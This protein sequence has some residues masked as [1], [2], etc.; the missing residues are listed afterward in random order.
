MTQPF[1][2]EL[3]GWRDLVQQVAVERGLAPALVE[4]D[5]WVVHC[6]WAMQGNGWELHFKGGTSL[7]KG[8]GIIKRFS[9]DL[10]L[11]ADLPQVEWSLPKGHNW[12]SGGRNALAEREKYFSSLAR[13]LAIPGCELAIEETDALHRAIKVRALYQ[14]S[15]GA[16]P[17]PMS[18]GVLLEFGNAR[19][20]PAME[21]SIQSWAMERALEADIVG[22]L[23]LQALSV[24]CVRPEVTL[25]E[26]I[27]A[28]VRRYPRQMPASKIIRHY[29]DCASIINYL[30]TAPRDGAPVLR[31]LYGQMLE[32]RDLQVD[33]AADSQLFAFEDSVRNDEL[34][35]DWNDAG[36]MHWG[37]RRPVDECAALIRDFVAAE[38]AAGL[39]SDGRGLRHNGGA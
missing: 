11:R 38:L 30:K 10:D 35:R 14:G 1:L 27:E 9:E 28:I 34:K 25:L 24:R 6:L 5:Y 12:K 15:L 3:E 26:K 19:V 8:Y 18:S 4:K 36:A 39:P 20:V 29:E 33:Y 16:M 37:V 22:F 23:A 7:S 31:D 2:H 32:T 13:E 17:S 21:C